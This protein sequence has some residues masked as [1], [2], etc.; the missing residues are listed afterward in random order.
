M[1]YPVTSLKDYEYLE[2]KSVK[3]FNIVDLP[4]AFPIENS[5]YKN[6]TYSPQKL[7]IIETL[8]LQL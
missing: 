7:H 8:D 1:E 4:I 6:Q 2:I 5:V 3:S